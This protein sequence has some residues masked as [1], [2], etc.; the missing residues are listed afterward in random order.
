MANYHLHL[1]CLSFCIIKSGFHMRIF[2]K[3]VYTIKLLEDRPVSVC[4]VKSLFCKETPGIS[5]D[6]RYPFIGRFKGIDTIVPSGRR[7]CSCR[8]YALQEQDGQIEEK[9]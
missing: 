9:V 5:I 7:H 4:T 8:P 2:F 6:F 3:N 1:A